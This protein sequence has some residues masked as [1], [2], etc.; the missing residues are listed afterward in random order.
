MTYREGESGDWREKD[1]DVEEW[2]G[3]GEWGN[4]VCQVDDDHK[5]QRAAATGGVRLFIF[6]RIRLPPKIQI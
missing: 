2:N 5:P 3:R 6:P 1:V 4:C